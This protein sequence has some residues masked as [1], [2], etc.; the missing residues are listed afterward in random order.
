MRPYRPVWQTTVGANYRLFWLHDPACEESENLAAASSGASRELVGWAANAVM[1]EVAAG[2]VG[3][4]LWIEVVDEAPGVDDLA[5]LQRDG[6]LEFPGGLLSVL[7]SLDETFQRGVA[8]SSGPD[9]YG[10]RVGGCGRARDGRMR[11]EGVEPGAYADIDAI[12]EAL[13]EW[14]A[15]GSFSGR[16]H[17]NRAGST[18]TKM[19]AL[20]RHNLPVAQVTGSPATAVFLSSGL[21]V[22]HLDICHSYGAE[23]SSNFTPRSRRAAV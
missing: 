16:R 12:V 13:A 3:I 10:V 4:D 17:P 20:G 14:S 8:L 18:T 15:T 2:L 19:S 23:D 9:T 11:D 5:D 1:V 21:S 22:S 7:Y 6:R